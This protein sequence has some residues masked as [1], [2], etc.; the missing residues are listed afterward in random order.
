ML[1]NFPLLSRH[2]VH[3]A[4]Q[5]LLC[6]LLFANVAMVPR[7]ATAA[8]LYSAVVGVSGQGAAERRTATRTALAEVLVKVTGNRQVAGLPGMAGALQDASSYIAQYGYR[9]KASAPGTRGR[10]SAQLP[11]RELVVEFDATAINQLLESH[12][13]P[14]W[15]QARPATLLWLAVEES[16]DNRYLLSND[17]LSALP[18][19]VATTAARRG[20]DV[21]LPLMD[22]ED[23]A[24]VRFADVW[25]DFRAPIVGASQRYDPAAV[26]VGRLS[27]RGNRWHGEWTLYQGGNPA[28][29]GADSKSAKAALSAGIGTM[30]DVLV[31]RYAPLMGDDSLALRR[32]RIVGIHSAQAYGVVA[33]YLASLTAIETVRTIEAAGDSLLVQLSLRGSVQSLR[34]TMSLGKVLVPVETGFGDEAETAGNQNEPVVE[35]NYRVQ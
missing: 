5:A 3:R 27:R 8:D 26:L 29:W 20:L 34:Q 14:V 2:S 33:G 9:L 24:A 19:L 1:L 35:L 21:S 12:H 15:D 32:M 28:A 7:F 17:S 10:T 23:Q 22:L 18:A 16:P 13:L 31:S 11:Q 30:A 6:C 25:G 4:C